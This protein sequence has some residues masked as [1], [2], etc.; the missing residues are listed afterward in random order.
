MQRA[1]IARALINEPRILL[2]DEPTGNLDS[3]TGAE[4]VSLLRDLNRQHGLTIIMVTHN[5]DM[6]ATTDR[7][8][9]LVAGRVCAEAEEMASPV[10]PLDNPLR[11]A[12]G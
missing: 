8:V 12:C 3:G 6:A 7:I 9:R 1:A 5:L 4:I 10:V 2:A 11:R